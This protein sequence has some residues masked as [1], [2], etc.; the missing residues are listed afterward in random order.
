M[1]VILATDAD[2][3]IDEVVAALGGPD[4]SF[5]VCREG[6]KVAGLVKEKTPDLVVL[7]VRM[8]PTFRD[9]GV[10]AAIRARERLAISYIDAEGRETHR[11]IRPLALE[12]AGRVR[13]VLAWCEGAGDFRAFRLDRIVALTAT[14]ETF[15]EEPG[16]RLADWARETPER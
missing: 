14:G 7:D 16:K 11:D 4:T 6:R 3:L 10:R 15:A 1:H 13:S 2:W 9:E 12:D 8:P 5:T